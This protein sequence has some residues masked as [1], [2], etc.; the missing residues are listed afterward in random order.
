[1]QINKRLQDEIIERTKAEDSL[2]YQ[3]EFENLTAAKDFDT[4]S[5]ELVGMCLYDLLPPKQELAFKD[6]IGKIMRSNKP[7]YFAEGLV[8]KVKD[9]NYCPILDEQGDP[10]QFSESG[11]Y[12]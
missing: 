1:M 5:D 4:H 9:E 2:H 7:V 12:S 10:A 6:L 8:G 11:P 3:I